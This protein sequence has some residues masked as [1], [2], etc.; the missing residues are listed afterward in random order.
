MAVRT[1]IRFVHVSNPG[2]RQDS[3]D[4]TAIRRHV[5][6]AV[7]RKRKNRDLHERIRLFDGSTYRKPITERPQGKNEA[8][9]RKSGPNTSQQHLEGKFKLARLPE[10]DQCL[11]LAARPQKYDTLL[12]PTFHVKPQTV[13]QCNCS[14]KADCG[15]GKLVT[16]LFGPYLAAC[17]PYTTC[18]SIHVPLPV[19]RIDALFKSRKLWL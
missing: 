7:L 4:A 11:G 14:S 6:Q 3:T 15:C 1:E 2:D 18:A 8:Q 9:P 16:G 17:H 19:Y 12:S 10:L 5:R 13:K